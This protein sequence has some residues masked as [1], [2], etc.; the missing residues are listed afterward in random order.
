MIPLSALTAVLA[1]LLLWSEGRGSR[2]GTCIIKPLASVGF[3]GCALAAGAWSSA[4]GRWVLMALVLCWLGDLFLLSRQIPPFRAGLFSFLAAHLCYAA[5]FLLMGPNWPSVAPAVILVGG[6]GWVV[7]QWLSPHVHPPMKSP[8]MA[9][10]LVISLMVVLGVGVFG[11]R[12]QAVFLAA[13]LAFYLSDLAVA[14]DRFIEP[15]FA[16]RLW[17]LPLYYTAQI[18]FAWSVVVA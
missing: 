10:I 17:G 5:A 3:V 15:G 1:L 16:N 8:V 14:R 11:R 18:L 4:Y 2:R 7:W 9:Y 6:V 12:G 13:P